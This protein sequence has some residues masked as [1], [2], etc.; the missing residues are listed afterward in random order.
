[1]KGDKIARGCKAFYQGVNDNFMPRRYLTTILEKGPFWNL[2]PGGSH[3]SRGKISLRKAD[4]QQDHIFIGIWFECRTD[5]V[6]TPSFFYGVDFRKHIAGYIPR[7]RADPR[8][9]TG[10][11]WPELPKRQGAPPCDVSGFTD[12]P[13]AEPSRTP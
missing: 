11:P 6:H 7:W 9:V 2:N 12:C 10:R 3:T 4:Y 8:P 1:M 13:L 5:G